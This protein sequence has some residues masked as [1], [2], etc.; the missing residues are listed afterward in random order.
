MS[1][2]KIITVLIAVTALI[3]APT[4][5][6]QNSPMDQDNA[7]STKAENKLIDN[8]EKLL[9]QI[10]Q[11]SNSEIQRRIKS[12]EKLSERV[13]AMQKI[14]E[15]GKNTIIAQLQ[16]QIAALNELKAKIAAGTDASST[17]EYDKKI[18]REHRVYSLT[19]PQGYLNAAVDRINAMVQKMEG[20]SK[21]LASKIAE[22]KAS[23]KDTAKLEEGIADMNAKINS[24]KSQSA[25]LKSAIAGL[26]Q[27][28][29]DAAIAAANRKALLAARE[30]IKTVEKDLKYAR[31]AANVLAK[32]LR[33]LG[34]K[35]SVGF[36]NSTSTP[37]APKNNT[38][39]NATSTI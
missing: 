20:L 29:G 13:E 30:S 11:K 21:K 39:T 2:K 22:L 35:T 26:E 14:T 36:G 8:G 18:A 1:N 12:L 27:D 33:T 25:A 34:I 24:A 7:T 3:A 31:N 5:F 32:Q 38:T 6:A 17:M 37:E 16:S 19:V 10:Q 23:G 28:K 9:S 4:A 15:S